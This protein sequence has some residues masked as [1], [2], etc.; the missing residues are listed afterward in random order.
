V[1]RALLLVAVAALTGCGGG[2]KSAPEASLDGCAKGKLVSFRVPGG[3]PVRALMLGD[4]DAGV[5]FSNDSGN[6]LCGWVSFAKD[7][8]DDGFRVLLYDY[9]YGRADGHIAP[10]VAELRRR[11]AKHVAIIGASLG[12]GATIVA[13][14]RPGTDVDTLVSLS[15][16]T[17]IHGVKE[18]VPRLRRPVFFVAA[19]GDTYGAGTDARTMYRD[20]PARDKKLLMIPG[21]EHGVDM[22][23]EKDLRD[24][25]VDWLQSHL[26]R[27]D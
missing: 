17:F 27:T 26:G 15:G 23:D 8:E 6:S 21:S 9:R 25:L 19:E 13:G 18:A 20:A 4:G 16:E 1:K 24:A 3:G 2:K 14:S 11:G 22:L 12:A 10:A 5:V 7:L